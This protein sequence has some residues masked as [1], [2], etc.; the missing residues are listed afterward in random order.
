MFALRRNERRGFRFLYLFSLGIFAFYASGIIAEM[1]I[2]RQSLFSREIG[3]IEDTIDAVLLISV[4]LL[5]ITMILNLLLLGA[6]Y[7]KE[8]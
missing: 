4:I 2:I 6:A 3:G 1:F 7:G 5:I 8:S